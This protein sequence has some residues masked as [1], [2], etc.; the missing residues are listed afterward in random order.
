MKKALVLILAAVM[1][2]SLFG[3]GHEEQ[4]VVEIPT[5]VP[6][7]AATKEPA[8]SP[9]EAPTNEPTP[10]PTEAATNEPTPSPTEAP[11][12]EPTSTP[13]PTAAP[14]PR[15]TSAPTPKP[16]A[17]PDHSAG[18]KTVFIGN[19]VLQSLYEYGLITNGFFLTKVGLNVNTIYKYT[20]DNGTVLIDVLRGKTFDKVV[21]NFGM[22]EVGWPSQETFIQRYKKVI[23]DIRERLPEGVRIYVLA[24]TPVTKKYSDGKGQENGITIEHIRSTNQRIKDMCAEKGAVFVDNPSEL[25][26]GE[27]YLPADA[28]ADGVHPNIRYLRIW[29]EHIRNETGV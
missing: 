27:G 20:D 3:C 17:D 9:T 7:E 11:T 26:D 1:A 28:S 19:S 10:S 13:H 25:I 8:P 21:I 24:I 29:A 4:V 15:P 22:N 5:L 2:L 12:A 23:D 14:T 18:D 6:T 16:T